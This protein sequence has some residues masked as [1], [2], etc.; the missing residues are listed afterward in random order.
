V[1][2]VDA[3]PT[4]QYKCVTPDDTN[5]MFILENVLPIG[6]D[7]RITLEFWLQNPEDNWGVV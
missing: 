5:R 4:D 3:V 7:D 1:T 2:L 6:Y